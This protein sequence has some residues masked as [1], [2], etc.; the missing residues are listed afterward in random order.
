MEIFRGISDLTRPLER[1]VLTIGNFD[2][3]HLGHRAI[4]ELVISRARSIGGES[5]LFTFEPHPRRVLRPESGL[6]LLETFDQKV[7]TLAEDM[8]RE[9]LHL[10]VVILPE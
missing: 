10:G 4:L 1:P 6:R 2:G 5:V 3:V 7:E 8:L 9:L